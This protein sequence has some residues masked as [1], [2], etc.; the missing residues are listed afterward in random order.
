M[1][2]INTLSNLWKDSSTPFIIHHDK[3]VYFSDL[4]KLDTADLSVIQPGQVVALIADFSPEA[5]LTLIKL[6]ELGA[7]IM[8]LSSETKSDHDYFL[9]CAGVEIIIENNAITEL[10]T[11]VAHPLIASLKDKGHA[12]L[13]LFSSGST[14]KP[15]GI[16]H[17]FSLFLARFSTPRQRLKTISFLLFDHIGGIN[18]LFHTLFNQGTIIVPQSR[19]IDDI[20]HA[21]QK[22]KAE[23]LPT[24]PTFLRMLLLSG[25]AAKAIPD[26]LKII[27]YG[28]EMM[29]ETTLK[30]LC[31][32]LPNIDFRQTYGMSELGILRIKS[33]AK[34]S[35][36]M[37][38]GGEGVETRMVD[39]LLH[40][41]SSNSMLGYLNSETPFDAQGWYNTKDIVIEEEGYYKI[42]GRS[43]DMLN[44]GG[45][46][47]HTNE[48]VSAAL[49]FKG[50]ERAK[51]YGKKNPITGQHAELI[52]QVSEADAFDK[53]ALKD[54]LKTKLHDYLLP[55]RIILQNIP[56]NHRFKQN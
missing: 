24:T 46:K 8:P 49:S 2:L 27:T 9:N 32:T 36:Y 12:G 54:F 55:R 3:P 19:H 48:I 42:A 11:K 22:H 44:I 40:I 26:T 20:L 21:C 43:D 6:I 29:D 17:D 51:A 38:I 31:E 28:T 39:N 47:F 35:L 14:G 7:I 33:K 5:I 41:R 45:L 15:K 18:T 53:T 23:L 52:V 50:V 34:N 56:I 4:E 10:K 25:K 13:V 30:M 1:T 37:Q 16:I